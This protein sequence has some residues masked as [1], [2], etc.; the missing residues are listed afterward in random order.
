[1]ILFY[2][3]VL[4]ILLNQ[5][6]EIMDSYLS[7]TNDMASLN[8]IDNIVRKIGVLISTKQKMKYNINKG[9]LIDNLILNFVLCLT[10]R[11]YHPL[12]S[13]FLPL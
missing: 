1:M 13:R 12:L 2:K 10:I 9:L 6:V 7:I 8:D 5:K 4:N 3:D 11:L